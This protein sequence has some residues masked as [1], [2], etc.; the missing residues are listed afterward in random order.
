MVAHGHQNIDNGSNL[1][2]LTPFFRNICA[3]VDGLP[4]QLVVPRTFGSTKIILEGTP[5]L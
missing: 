5:H 4:N 1:S 2:A 3:H